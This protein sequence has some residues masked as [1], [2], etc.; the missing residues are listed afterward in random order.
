MIGIN[1]VNNWEEF[2]FAFETL[3]DDIAVHTWTHPYMTTLSNLD[4]L[5]Q[6]G[7]SMQLIHNSTGGRVP[8]FWRPPYGDAD[9][10]VRAIAS[11]VFNLTT[12]VW[13][14]EYGLPFRL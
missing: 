11:Q 8:K 4:V 3:G 1:I 12:I 13:N 6:F 5:A 14:Q 7:W 9:N 10:R 2:L